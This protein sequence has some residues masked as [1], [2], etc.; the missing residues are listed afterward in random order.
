MIWW[1]SAK[2]NILIS[3]DFLWND[4]MTQIGDSFLAVKVYFNNRQRP[5]Q[6]PN[7]AGCFCPQTI[8]S[9]WVY[10]TPSSML[11]LSVDFTH[12]QRRHNPNQ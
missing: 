11:L 4:L 1:R 7:T 6:W 3:D 2:E 9:K 10:A 12:R 5:S 8:A